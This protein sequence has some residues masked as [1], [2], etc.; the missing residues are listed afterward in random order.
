MPLRQVRDVFFMQ[1]AFFEDVPV[2]RNRLN[3]FYGY[4]F[5]FGVA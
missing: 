3:H 5:A 2:A 4:R 1:V